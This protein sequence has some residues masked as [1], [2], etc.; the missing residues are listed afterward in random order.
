MGVGNYEA[1]ADGHMST[2]DIYV[3]ML[4]TNARKGIYLGF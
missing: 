2:A 1:I 3:L 4:L